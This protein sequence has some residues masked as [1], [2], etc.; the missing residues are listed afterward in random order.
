MGLFSRLFGRGGPGPDRG[1]GPDGGIYVYVRCNGLARRPCGEPLRVRIDPA[2]DL[3]EEYEGD[4]ERISGYTVHKEVL[5]TW[6]QNMMQVTIHY[7][8]NRR[9]TGRQ[10]EGAT[11]IDAAAYERLRQETPARPSPGDAGGPGG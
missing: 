6:C 10:V 11:L 2:H 9:E 3:L 8:A 5:G 7:D 1:A 4:E